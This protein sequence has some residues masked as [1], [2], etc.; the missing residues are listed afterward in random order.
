MR[1]REVIAVVGGAAAALPLA[2]SSQRQAPLVGFLN[3]ASCGSGG[4]RRDV[5]NAAIVLGLL[6]WPC[7][8]EGNE[9]CQK[10]RGI[11]LANHAF[12]VA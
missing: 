8:F 10:G 4:D 1:R 9:P 3:S 7:Q 5:V 2:A 12:N 6:A 11:Y